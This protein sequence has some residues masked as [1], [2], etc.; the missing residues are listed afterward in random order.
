MAWHGWHT[1]ASLPPIAP[2]NVLF[3]QSV[4][5]LLPSVSE[6]APAEQFTHTVQVVAAAVVEY[7]PASQFVQDSLP[8]AIL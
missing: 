8:L 6:Y 4:H 5:A 2:E 3:G 1:D 7:V